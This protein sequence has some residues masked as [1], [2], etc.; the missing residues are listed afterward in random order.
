MRERKEFKINTIILGLRKLEMEISFTE[1]GKIT[2]GENSVGIGADEVGE[3]KSLALDFL[4]QISRNQS[5]KC[6]KF[7][8][9]SIHV[10]DLKIYISSHILV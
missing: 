2:E 6:S 10:G 5:K 4:F 9:S 8:E 3:N 7:L 1:K